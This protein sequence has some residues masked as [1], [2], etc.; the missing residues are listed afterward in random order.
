M[1][2]SAHIIISHLPTEAFLGLCTKKKKKKMKR[3][4]N[5]QSDAK[6][7]K[8]FSSI[9]LDIVHLVSERIVFRS[10]PGVLD[11]VMI[12]NRYLS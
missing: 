4:L 2:I 7:S 9:S 1:K 12:Q 3:N 6:T 5:E 10:L 11:V 8:P